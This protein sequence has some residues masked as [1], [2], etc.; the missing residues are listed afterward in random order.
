MQIKHRIHIEANLT[1]VDYTV[2]YILYMGGV[3]LESYT[4]IYNSEAVCD[5]FNITSQDLHL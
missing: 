1:A 4:R 2:C 3:Y 5:I